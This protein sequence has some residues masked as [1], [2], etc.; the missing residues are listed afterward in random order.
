MFIVSPSVWLVARTE[1]LQR[2][3]KK[4]LENGRKRALKGPKIKISKNKKLRFFLMSQGVLCQKIRFLGQKLWP[5]AGEQT[6]THTDTQTE[7]LITE[8]PI[9]ASAF[10]ASACDMSGPINCIFLQRF[11]WSAWQQIPLCIHTQDVYGDRP[12]DNSNVTI[13][14]RHSLCLFYTIMT[15]TGTHSELTKIQ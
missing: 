1:E 9:K 3:K 5:L 15:F 4:I 6:E 11:Q 7:V 13:G 12:M 10:Q 8:Y 14:T 2:I